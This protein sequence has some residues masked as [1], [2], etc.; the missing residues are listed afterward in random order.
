MDALET[1][2]QT[3]LPHNLF[4]NAQDVHNGMHCNFEEKMWQVHDSPIG[5]HFGYHKTMHALKRQKYKVPGLGNLVRRYLCGCL[6]CQRTKPCTKKLAAPLVPNDVPDGPWETIAWDMIGPLPVSDGNNAIL[7]T[8]DLYSKGVKFEG[9]QTELT[10]EGSANFM[11]N[12][13]YQE[14]GLP[15]KIIC[16][17]G[18]Q[19]V[20]AFMKEFFRL[21][22]I[23]GNP[24][25]AYHPQTDGQ[26]ERMNREIKR[27]LCAFI[28][29]HQGN[30]TR[31]LPTGEFTLNNSLASATGFLPFKVNKGRDPRTFPDSP[32]Y[33]GQV[34]TADEF[35]KAIQRNC[36]QA[37]RALEKAKQS[38]KM[39]YDKHRAPTETYEDGELV[40]VSAEHLPSNR[41]TAKL[42]DK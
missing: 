30:W 40:M 15:L 10:S 3:L 37:K 7:V 23:K 14:E 5:G 12:Q 9:T 38:M 32:S 2:E 4:I 18:P 39:Y 17:H 22:G 13:V 6:I 20:A 11:L 31:W 26:T 36:E 19:F 35:V 29:Y 34:P 41:P 25:T 21:V 8:V 16:D 28:D 27:Y 24:S 33:E 1:K 42:D